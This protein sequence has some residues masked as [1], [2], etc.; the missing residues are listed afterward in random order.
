MC[1]LWSCSNLEPL[2]IKTWGRMSGLDTISMD[3]S[4][5][6]GINVVARTSTRPDGHLN[7]HFSG[8]FRTH[9][10]HAKHLLCCLRK[11]LPL[12][13]Y[14]GKSLSIDVWKWFQLTF[15]VAGRLHWLIDKYNLRYFMTHCEILSLPCRAEMTFIS[16]LCLTVRFFW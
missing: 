8:P 13:I 16:D 14:S 7:S 9:K 5:R 12:L 3:F 4:L 10:C 6:T 11:G 15:K 1:D 2:I